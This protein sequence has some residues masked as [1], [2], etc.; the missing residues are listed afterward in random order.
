M[1]DE[2]ILNKEDYKPFFEDA[3][4]DFKKEAEPLQNKWNIHDISW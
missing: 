2:W 4:V 3:L 1:V